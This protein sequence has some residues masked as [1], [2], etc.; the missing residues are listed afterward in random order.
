MFLSPSK[1]NSTGW[2][3]Y[4]TALLGDSYLN[5]SFSTISWGDASI[6]LC[7]IS[8]ERNSSFLELVQSAITFSQSIHGDK[9]WDKGVLHR[10]WIPSH[11][12]RGLAC[13]TWSHAPTSHW[14]FSR[15][16]EC[17]VSDLKSVVLTL[18]SNLPSSALSFASCGLSPWSWYCAPWALI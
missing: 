10:W 18:F 3:G 12:S 6:G 17:V 14:Q 5:P 2:A 16:V 1:T 8:L 4:P 7:T 13:Q 9:W 11:C 15:V